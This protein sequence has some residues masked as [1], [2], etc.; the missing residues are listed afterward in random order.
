MAYYRRYQ[1]DPRWLDSV[2]YPAVCTRCGKPIKRGDRA[3]YYPNGRHLYCDGPGCGQDC[4]ADFQSA[5]EDEYLNSINH[6]M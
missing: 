4:A 3:F 5:A 6:V 2:R 1:G